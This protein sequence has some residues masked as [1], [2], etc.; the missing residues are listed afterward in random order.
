MVAEEK[1]N[2]ITGYDVVAIISGLGIVGWIITDFFGGMIIWMF[3]Y[4]VIISSIVL[5]YVFSFLDTLISL[6]RKGKATSKVKLVAHGTVL[7]VIL[8]FNLYHSEL[9]KSKS[10]MIASLKDD[11]F[12]YRLIFRENGNV[13]NQINGFFGFSETYHGK[14]K[15]EKD[16]IIF[17]EKPY[18]ND[19][20]PDTL[21]IDK[22]QNA[23]FMEKDSNGDFRTEK[24]WLN[25]FEIE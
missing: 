22:S 4:G 11:L 24:N 16:L 14:Y 13:E 15:I 3:S 8:G 23:L 10:I 20:I 19:F 12:Y 7:L 21:L 25:H 9:F 6:F 2:R 1:Q 5:L 18:D 17:S